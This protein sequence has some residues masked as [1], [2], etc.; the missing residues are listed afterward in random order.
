MIRLPKTSAVAD[1]PASLKNL[2]RPHYRAYLRAKRYSAAKI[3]S[4]ARLSFYAPRHP[5][6]NRYAVDLFLFKIVVS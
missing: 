6:L 1:I 5:G 4:P 3:A 2:K